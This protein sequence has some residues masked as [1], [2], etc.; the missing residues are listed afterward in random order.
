MVE[1]AYGFTSERRAELEERIF[2]AHDLPAFA[3]D[4]KRVSWEDG[5]KVYFTGA[6]G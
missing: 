5:C 3:H 6:A 1:G 2:C 4:V